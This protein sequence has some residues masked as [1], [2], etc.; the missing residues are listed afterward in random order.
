MTL[1]S[2]FGFLLLG[3][4]SSSWLRAPLIASGPKR[5]TCLLVIWRPALSFGPQ[6]LSGFGRK[7]ATFLAC[8]L[9]RDATARAKLAWKEHI[10]EKF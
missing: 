3:S 1:S 4:S 5:E 2:V 9:L 8:A 7:R 6:C 10:Q